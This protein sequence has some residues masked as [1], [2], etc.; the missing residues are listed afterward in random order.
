MR[1][2]NEISLLFLAVV[3]ALS[4]AHVRITFPVARQPDFDFLDNI[5]TQ[6][7]CGVMRSDG[8]PVTSLRSGQSINVTWHLAYAHRGGVKIDMLDYN[9][10]VIYNL[11]N[12][13]LNQD[14]T[15]SQQVEV[16][17]PEFGCNN[18]TIRLLRQA[19]EWTTS[20]DEGYIFWSCA[21]V[22]ITD[23][24]ECG[25]EPDTNTECFESGNCTD[26]TCMCDAGYY[27]DYCQY[28]DECVSS[29]DCSNHGQCLDTM[30][31]TS[32]LKVCYCEQGWFGNDCSKQNPSDFSV[33]FKKRDYYHRELVS[34]FDLYWKIL[35]NRNEV[36]IALEVDST[37]WIGL[38]WK[39]TGLTSACKDFP[40][41]YRSG[42]VSSGSIRRTRR[43]FNLPD[44]QDKPDIQVQLLDRFRRDVMY[45][46]ETAVAPEPE[47]EPEPSGEPEGEPEPSG[48]PEGEPEPSGEPEGEPEPSS[49]PEGEPEPSSE[50]EG[51]PEPSG[52][53]E[54]GPAANLHPM[55]CTDLVIGSVKMGSLSHISDFY[56]RDRS[57]PRYDEFYNMGTD[58]ILAADG[59][60]V[61]GKTT[62][63]FR[64]KLLASEMSDHS[65]SNSL[66][67][68]IWARGQT[69][70]D[71]WHAPASGIESCMAEDYM[72]YRVDE[73]KYHGTRADQRGVTTMNFYDDP[74]ATSVSGPCRGEWA[75]PTGCQGG[76]C[77][78][79]ATWLYQ[80]EDDTIVF[81]IQSKNGRDSNGDVN[82][83]GI[84]FSDDKLMAKSDMVVGWIMDDGQFEITDRWA[85]G[86]NQPQIDSKENLMNKAMS[87][88]NGITT[89]KFT[90]K[91]N[92]HD[93]AADV[94]FSDDV[95]RY[96][97]F[98]VSG[99][100]VT[101]HNNIAI[102]IH[103]TTPVVSGQRICIKACSVIGVGGATSIFPAMVVVMVTSIL[104]IVVTR[105]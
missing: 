48:E 31:T 73:L 56:T 89:M 59:K 75:T 54:P 21:D 8:G 71:Y 90:R 92:T 87:D 103:S 50:P 49:E 14:D 77:D 46:C 10:D 40:V 16:T 36:E 58:G 91:R 63:V 96:M 17:L 4:R 28:S 99:G 52:E 95:C 37:T 24:A 85:T 98:P 104:S 105:I 27:G 25:N 1:R 88:V 86:H 12:G 51:E 55:D 5:R 33:N 70:G 102:G 2:T 44:I 39:P 43:S 30:A 22:I 53:P 32:P 82:W 41:D 79:R 80:I 42:R 15:T 74:D 38:G 7:P 100:S 67:S 81:E 101:N 84:G 47:G 94:S 6:G 45:T 35:Q 34:G 72:F 97:F 57:T 20:R 9:G 78:Y 19:G 69:P 68:V 26:G 64:K 62:I 18:C 76:E 29:A 60:E 65:I 66:M 13:F 11:T 83:L 3:V 93:N 23:N 61:D